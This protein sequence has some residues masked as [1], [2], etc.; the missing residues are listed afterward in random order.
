MVLSAL[1]PDLRAFLSTWDG[2]R[3]L[4]FLGSW[5][6]GK[7]WRVVALARALLERAAREEWTTHLVAVPGLL[8]ELRA[9]YD[10]EQQGGETFRAVFK[11][12]QGT[13]LLILDDWAKEKATDARQRAVPQAHQFSLRTPA[14]DVPRAPT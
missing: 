12:Y 2:W 10:P 7:A 6:L 4:L 1:P 5:G 14:A 9:G 11:R 13:R 8:D 3:S